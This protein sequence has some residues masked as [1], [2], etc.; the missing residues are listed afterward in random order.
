MYTTAKVIKYELHDVIRSKWILIYA[1]FFLVVTEALFRFGGGSAR[2]LVSLSNVVLI[3]IPLV[4]IMFGTMYLYNARSF[5]ELLLTQ[6]VNR[7]TLFG[8][9]YAGLA[10]PLSAGFLAGAGV[11]FALHGVESASHGATL[12]TLA[13]AGVLLTF[14]FVALAFWIAV[15]FEDKV[16]GL[17]VSI[18]VWLLFAVLYDG[19]VLLLVNLLADY[20]L[21]QPMIGMMLLNPIDLARVLL[22]LTF[23]ASA[24]MGYT[25]AVFEQFFGSPLGVVIS[26][27]ALTVWFAVPLVLGWRWFK[28]KDF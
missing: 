28:K 1:L 4:S 21:E 20:P 24:L 8:G 23:D 6:P 25:G 11:P 7:R 19:L 3:I 12:L 9:L 2:A 26:T 5:I 27:T 22:L 14:V 18:L 16:R 15:T 17:G 10:L 13:V